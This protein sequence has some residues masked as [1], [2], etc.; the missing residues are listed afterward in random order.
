VQAVLLA[1][2][3]PAI[4]RL[5]AL[6]VTRS[7][8]SVDVLQML[9]AL[10]ALV[11]TVRYGDVRRTD[12]ATLSGVVVALAERATVGVVPASLE[13]D[14]DAADDLGGSI[15]AATQSLGL[16]VDE[17]LRGVIDDWWTAL[18]QIIDRREA[19][20]V[21]RGTCTR[22]ALNAERLAMPEAED[23]LMRALAR[24]TPPA[25]A[26]RWLEGFLSPNLGGS[27]LM[28]ASS[29]RLFGLVDTWLTSLSDQY[30]SEVLPLLRRTTSG[31]SAGERRQIA[32]RV[33]HGQHSTLP[34]EAD[35]LD[36]ARAALVEPVLRHILG[37]E[38]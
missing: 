8:E 19:A 33:R 35:Q 37:L 30:F 34:V 12:A 4:G 21:V 32:E 6:L 16:L 20:P 3:E 27:G 28:L 10:P 9:R 22:L 24:G 31:F 11:A 14:D 1:D 5:V 36:L 29:T 38:P 15:L 17:G 2:L 13:L 26:A 25:E 23:C 7:A 18:R